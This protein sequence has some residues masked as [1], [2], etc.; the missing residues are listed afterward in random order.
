MKIELTVGGS[1]AGA[2]YHMKLDGKWYNLLPRP[3]TGGEEHVEAAK[4][5]AEKI[6]LEQTGEVVSLEN[7]EFRHDGTL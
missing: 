6:I 3:V 7:A 5:Q 1:F 2:I 4:R